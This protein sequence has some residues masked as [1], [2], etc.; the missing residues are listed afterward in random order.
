MILDEVEVAIAAENTKSPLDNNNTTTTT[1]TNKLNK[2]NHVNATTS[3]PQSIIPIRYQY[4]QSAN[5]LNLSVLAKNLISDD[6]QIEIQENHLKVVVVHHSTSGD[7]GKEEIVIDKDLFATIDT[8]QSKYT[9]L[10]SKVEIS[11]VKITPE[12][13]PTLEITPGTV[14]LPPASTSTSVSTDNSLSVCAATTNKRPKAYSS[15]KDWDKVESQIVKDLEAE[16][17]EGEEALQGLFQQIYKDAD[18]E[19]RMAMK[20]SFQTSGGTVLS[21]NW[22][23]SL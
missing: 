10:K 16:K 8:L 4:Y 1:N 22:K 18:P 15:S 14:R 2:A 13:W 3:N 12:L 5:C 20:K 19:T 7:K 9:I 6:L 11:L 23:V 17:P 21:T